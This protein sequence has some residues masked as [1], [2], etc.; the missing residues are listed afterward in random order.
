MAEVHV[1]ISLAD[2]LLW[3][4]STRFVIF[5]NSFTYFLKGVG[6]K[7][8]IFELV[9]PVENIF[10]SWECPT[11]LKD[12]HR[13]LIPAKSMPYARASR[14]LCYSVP[15]SVPLCSTVYYDCTHLHTQRHIH[16]RACKTEI[17]QRRRIR[18]CRLWEK[19]HS[20]RSPAAWRCPS[21]NRKN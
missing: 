14:S 20:R 3:M 16:E 11:E 19:G 8:R 4:C 6:C 5:V 18:A 15:H 10:A 13:W 9:L 12:V 21:K 7:A 1:S 17:R 2:E